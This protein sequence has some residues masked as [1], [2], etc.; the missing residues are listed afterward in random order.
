[1]SR[2]RGRLLGKQ[3]DD[4]LLALKDKGDLSEVRRK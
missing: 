4:L 2:N 3:G 1:M